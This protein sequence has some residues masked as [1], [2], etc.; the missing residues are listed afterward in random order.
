MIQETGYLQYDTEGRLVARVIKSPEGEWMIVPE[1]NYPFV[2]MVEPGLVV[3][4][5]R[6]RQRPIEMAEEI[7]QE[8]EDEYSKD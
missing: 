2:L 6:E 4:W 8:S 1:P 7:K 5:D 3:M